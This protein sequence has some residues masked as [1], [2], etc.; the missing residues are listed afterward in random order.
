MSIEVRHLSHIYG[1]GSAIRTVAL[2]DI[3]F[4]VE[5]GE[6]VG[7]V[8]HTGSG[9][10]AVGLLKEEMRRCNSL[11]MRAADAARVPA[12]GALAVDR[13]QF[14][15]CITRTLREHPLVTVTEREITEIPDG[16]VI[17]ATGPLT[18]EALARAIGEL[19]EEER[20]AVTRGSF[21][22]TS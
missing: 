6:F 5:Q 17:I 2:D 21:S 19:P 15:G 1:E 20:P 10:Y 12:G 3:S 9:E 13:E 8:G 16:P 11:I 7:I 22:S 18:S 14:S 4:T